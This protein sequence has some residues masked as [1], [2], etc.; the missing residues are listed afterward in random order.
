VENKN[1]TY[2][3]GLQRRPRRRDGT[4]EKPTSAFEKSKN[5]VKHNKAHAETL[6]KVESRNKE[7]EREKRNE[8]G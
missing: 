6:D 3:N 1:A 2:T 8:P 7:E 5:D 4:T